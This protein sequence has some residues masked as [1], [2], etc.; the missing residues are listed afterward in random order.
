MVDFSLKSPA[1]EHMGDITQ[2]Y[3]CQGENINPPLLI[4]NVPEKTESL[5]LIMEDPDAPGITVTHWIICHLEPSTNEIS[6]GEH[7]KNA[8]IGKNMMG[9]NEYMG[10]C[11]PFGKHRYF[12]KLYALNKKLDINDKTRKKQLL[13]ASKGH[14]IEQTELIG[15][16]KKIKT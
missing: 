14:I 5:I 11:P 7:I 9:K 10:P 6:E 2:K 12:F 15:L 8:I 4:S 1:F 13:K 3:T 16:Y